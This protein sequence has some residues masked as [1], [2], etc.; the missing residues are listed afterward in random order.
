MSLNSSPWEGIHFHPVEIADDDLQVLQ[1]LPIFCQFVDTVKSMWA[2]KGKRCPNLGPNSLADQYPGRY[3]GQGFDPNRSSTRWR[4]SQPMPVHWQQ[5][6]KGVIPTELKLP[7]LQVRY[8][9]PQR[10]YLLR[11]LREFSQV[12]TFLPAST[13]L[14][15]F[16]ARSYLIRLL[17]SVILGVIRL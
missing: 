11:I 2:G 12:K 6:I 16:A 9:I 13:G 7:I 10:S 5:N 3:H 14:A 17:K 8:L 4:P 1:K 15:S